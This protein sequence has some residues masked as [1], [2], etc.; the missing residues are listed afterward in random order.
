M[1]LEIAAIAALLEML[2]RRALEAGGLQRLAHRRA[3]VAM[4]GAVDVGV[5]RACRRRSGCRSSGPNGPPRRP[6]RR[7][8]RRD[9]P[10]RDPRQARAPPRGRRSRPS[11]RRASRRAAGY[12]SASRSGC[13]GRSWGCGRSPCRRRRSPAPA[14]PPSCGRRANAGSRRPAARDAGDARRSRSG[15]SR[16]CAAGRPR[17]RS[18]LILGM[19]ASVNAPRPMRRWREACRRRGAGRRAGRRAA[20]PCRP[21]PAGSVTQGVP[22]SVQIELKRG[23]PV[24]SGPSAPRPARSG[25]A[26]RRHRRTANRHGP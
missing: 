21:C 5:G 10:S 20:G 13:A 4:A 19:S 17:S 15:R 22:A 2:A 16:R 9:A 23:S 18:P 11:R 3:V 24:N 7:R 12:R 25:R 6:T 26:A 8:R 1:R 14:P